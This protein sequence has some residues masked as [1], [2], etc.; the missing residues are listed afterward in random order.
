MMSY[1]SHT[2]PGQAP[3]RQFTSTCTCTLSG[4][5]ADQVHKYSVKNLDII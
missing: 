1:P 5:A 4:I 3:Q 2:V